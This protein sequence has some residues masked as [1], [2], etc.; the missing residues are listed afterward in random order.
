MRDKTQQVVVVVV[1]NVS[2][3]TPPSGNAVIVP[4]AG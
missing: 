2:M 3:A 4:A 1:D